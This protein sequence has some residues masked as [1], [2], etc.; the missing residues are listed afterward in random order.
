MYPVFRIF[1]KEVREGWVVIAAPD[2]ERAKSSVLSGGFQS[3]G[4]VGCQYS[5]RVTELR[6]AG[7]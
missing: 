6:Q 4:Q 7:E 3:T 1:I 5:R 2:E